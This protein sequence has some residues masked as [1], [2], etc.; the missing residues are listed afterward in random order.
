ML[1]LN[2]RAID[3]K[4]GKNAKMTHL[5]AVHSCLLSNMRTQSN[6]FDLEQN[7]KAS[8]QNFFEGWKCIT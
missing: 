8:S 5:S 3:T 1:K 7:V 2:A 6:V 4:W